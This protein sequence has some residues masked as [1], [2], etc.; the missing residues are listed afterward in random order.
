MTRVLVKIMETT[1]LV[2]LNLGLFIPQAVIAICYS[3]IPHLEQLILKI[4]ALRCLSNLSK[5]IASPQ[6]S[7]VIVKY[8]Y[9]DC[10]IIDF[11][12]VYSIMAIAVVFIKQVKMIILADLLQV[13]E[14]MILLGLVVIVGVFIMSIQ[15][16]PRLHPVL[17]TERF[18]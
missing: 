14:V 10:F 5:F 6:L 12:E 1:G 16:V 4:Q 2:K 18:H 17:I 8:L 13:V 11:M 3:N 9:I 15:F 7:I